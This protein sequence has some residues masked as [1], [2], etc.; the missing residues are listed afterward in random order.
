MG[1]KNILNKIFKSKG[2]N[3]PSED[4]SKFKLVSNDTYCYS[5]I[6]WNSAENLIILLSFSEDFFSE[7][8]DLQDAIINSDKGLISKIVYSSYDE[9]TDQKDADGNSLW[10][11]H[12]KY[13]MLIGGHPTSWQ[14]IFTNINDLSKNIL[15]KISD[16]IEN[17]CRAI[18]FETVIN[19]GILTGF[20]YDTE[21]PPYDKLKVTDSKKSSYTDPEVLLSRLPNGF[22]GRDLLKFIKVYGEYS[23]DSDA[24]SELYY[25]YGMDDNMF[26]NTYEMYPLYASLFKNPTVSRLKML[27][28]PLYKQPD[29]DDIAGNIDDESLDAIFREHYERFSAVADSSIHYEDI[30]EQLAEDEESENMREDDKYE[31]D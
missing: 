10:I 1:L 28:D 19:D 4:Y 13:Y 5:N 20:K 3:L 31:T 21:K 18:H 2:S 16:E 14:N 22:T 29:D 12:K 27:L 11:I 23:N 30:D 15:F 25:I 17:N 24:F 6:I 8:I 9:E 26:K 7:I